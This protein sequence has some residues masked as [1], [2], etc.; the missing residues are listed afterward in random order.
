[1]DKK[2][3]WKE[4]KKHYIL[5]LLAIAFVI[6]L[7]GLGVYGVIQSNGVT[8]IASIF[9]E[10]S[11]KTS[12]Q[13]GKLER[14]KKELIE[15]E[16]QAYKRKIALEE[17]VSMDFSQH[18]KGTH[19][20]KSTDT[21]TLNKPLV[22][23][24]REIKE[25]DLPKATYSGKVTLLKKARS[26]RMLSSI[27][28]RQSPDGFYIIKADTHEPGSKEKASSTTFA[29]AVIH[30]NQKVKGSGTVCLRLLEEAAFGGHSYPKNSILYGRVRGVISGRV[31]I[32]I[33]QV[34]GAKLNLSVYDGDYSEGIACKMNEVVD[35]VARES[36]DDVLNEALSSL[37][38][39][40]VAGGIAQ[41]GR[42]VIRRTKRPPTIYL[43]D[44]YRIFLA[45]TK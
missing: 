34:K 19:N 18:I 41:L 30:G 33:S 42:S 25:R 22:S 16:K 45:N 40:G 26:K 32:T 10:D 27:E 12:L 1:M 3:L 15:G 37:P 8:P 4:L 6:L 14:Y 20:Q 13:P 35:Q 2:T 24:F 21:S 5:F 36:R 23:T 43:A 39:G 38:Y 11:L 28:K 7:I 9:P 44:G 31:Q 29:K 17:I